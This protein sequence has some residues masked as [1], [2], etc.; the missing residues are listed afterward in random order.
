MLQKCWGPVSP[1]GGVQPSCHI[2][3]HFR[4]LSVLPAS[5]GRTD[6]YLAQ[7][8]PCR[9]YLGTTRY[10]STSMH[11]ALVQTCVLNSRNTALNQATFKNSNQN[12]SSSRVKCHFSTVCLSPFP[13]FPSVIWQEF[14]TKGSHTAPSRRTVW[15]GSEDAE[16]AAEAMW[17][18]LQG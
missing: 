16:R 15:F 6:G 14:K 12:Y 9:S 4:R 8:R 2:P 7:A 18:R 11:S 5:M 13:V 17:L 10:Q 1:L 3:E